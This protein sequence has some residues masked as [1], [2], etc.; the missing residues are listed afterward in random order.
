L[1]FLFSWPLALHIVPVIAQST[2]T[3]YY[4]AFPFGVVFHGVLIQM[5]IGR[6]E[7]PFLFALLLLL[8][9][10]M[11]F[12]TR[13]FLVEFDNAPEGFLSGLIDSRYYPLDIALY[14]LLFN[15]IIYYVL[16]VVERD[17]QKISKDKYLIERK[18][19]EILDTMEQLR[20][21][22]KQLIQS[23]KLS[24]IGILAG[25]VAHEINN[26]L[27]RLYGQLE[28]LKRELLEPSGDLE[29][30]QLIQQFKDDLNKVRRV[31]K[32]MQL[33]AVDNDKLVELDLDEIISNTIYLSQIEEKEIAVDYSIQKPLVIK[34]F[35]SR[36]HRVLM[37]ILDNATFAVTSSHRDNKTV[38]IAVGKSENKLDIEI[39]NNGDKI[40]DEYLQKIFD[41]FFTLKEAGE[42][43]GLGLFVAYQLVEEMQG[44]L[45]VSQSDDW[46][47]FHI[48]IPIN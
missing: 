39:S 41:P 45:Q 32:S 43:L 34:C 15:F 6:K 3:D 44:S 33:A 12:F 8:N 38:R 4:L 9:F 27:N 26:P 17:F 46:V 29:I 18:N 23:E 36:L 1:I 24:S 5:M 7:Y 22:Q 30:D 47:S 19:I 42:G 40:P 20:K 28:L 35:A 48:Q 10:T 11:L 25:G 31:T 37:A 21:T 13:D 2:P 16:A 14:W